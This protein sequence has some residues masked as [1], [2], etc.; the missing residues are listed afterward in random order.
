MDWT[1]QEIRFL[2]E[3]YKERIP[4]E[5]ISKR[6]KRSKKS[7]KRKAQ[8]LGL[9]RERVP[10]NKSKSRQPQNVI[11]KRYY[12]KNK[13]EIY[14]RKM[15]RRK[16]LKEEAIKI[17]G[18]KC[19]VCGYDKCLSALEFHHNHEDKEGHVSTFIKKGSRQ[20]VLKEAEK[21]II[22]CANCHRELHYKGSVV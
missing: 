20:K 22:L 21:C 4:L 10:P 15:N 1:D 2:R 11:D 16:K 13:E 6:L 7:I 14:R 17:S 8:N 18:G 3:I 9:H 5:E 12:E 19:S